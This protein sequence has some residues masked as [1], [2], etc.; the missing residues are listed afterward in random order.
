[1]LNVFIL[2]RKNWFCLIKKKRIWAHILVFIVTN[3]KYYLDLKHEVF[4]LKMNDILYFIDI[5]LNKKVQKVFLSTI[6][7]DIKNL[8]KKQNSEPFFFVL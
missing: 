3:Y 5:K 2:A 4:Y 1:M 8:L 6:E 7:H